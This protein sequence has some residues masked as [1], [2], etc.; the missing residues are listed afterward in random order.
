[1]GSPDGEGEGL[2]GSEDR[3]RN[4]EPTV[5]VDMPRQQV[6]APYRYTSRTLGMGTV[7]WQTK[8]SKMVTQAHPEAAQPPPCSFWVLALRHPSIIPSMR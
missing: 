4:C 6:H 2:E 8:G 1:M 7:A 3:T 5:G